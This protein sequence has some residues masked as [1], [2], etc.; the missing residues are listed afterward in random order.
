MEG[1]LN[2]IF[3]YFGCLFFPYISRIPT[4]YIGVSYLHFRYYW[5]VLVKK[6]IPPQ[7]K[8]KKKK[9]IQNS[10]SRKKNQKIRD[11]NL[12]MAQLLPRLKAVGLETFV[13]FSTPSAW[14]RCNRDLACGF[15]V[16]PWDWTSK[17][18]INVE[19]GQNPSKILSSWESKVP[20]PM[21]PPPNK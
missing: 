7:N 12:H 6:G 10:L 21:P 9:T 1:F 11:P 14:Q 5:D 19:S 17:Q 13:F 8:Q 3:G 18:F 4:A 20:P 2:L 16:F 15:D